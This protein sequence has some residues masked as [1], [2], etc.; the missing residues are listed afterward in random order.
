M[1]PPDEISYAATGAEYAVGS[2]APPPNDGNSANT[3]HWRA[4]DQIAGQLRRAGFRDIRVDQQQVRDGVIV[5]ENRPDIQ[6]T[7]RRGRRVIV[8]VDT[9]RN[10]SLR[11]QRIVTALDPRATSVFVRL[12]PNTGRMTNRVIASPQT[13]GRSALRRGAFRLSDLIPA[14]HGR[15][16]VWRRTGPASVRRRLQ[17]EAESLL[18]VFP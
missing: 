10:E 18:Q 9:D 1:A 15:R 17:R 6:A 5:G 13:Q 8:E 3:W 14:L 12:D 16:L 4:V 11:H 2:P 7:D